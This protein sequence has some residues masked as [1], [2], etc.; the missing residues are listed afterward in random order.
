VAPVY[1]WRWHVQRSPETAA[2]LDNQWYQE[3]ARH[4]HQ[5]YPSPWAKSRDGALTVTLHSDGFAHAPP[6]EKERLK[7]L[8]SF[9]PGRI[10]AVCTPA[11]GRGASL[12]MLSAL[13]S[14]RYGDAFDS[15]VAGRR[16][17]VRLRGTY[18][19]MPER[20]PG[21][22][23]VRR[24]LPASATDEDVETLRAAWND[25]QAHTAL[26]RAAF[27]TAQPSLLRYRE[28]L[29]AQLRIWILSIDEALDYFETIAKGE[30]E[31]FLNSVV[32]TDR[33]TY[34]HERTKQVVRTR[35][36]VW[37]AVGRWDDPAR[38]DVRDYLLS[39]DTR[40]H[41]LL[42]ARDRIG[43][44]YYTSAGL[45]ANDAVL[46]HLNYFFLLVTAVFDNLAWILR[47]VYKLDL[48]KPQQVGVRRSE[49]KERINTKFD[50]LFAS[51]ES[52]LKVF[53]GTRHS[54]AHRL[55]MWGIGFRDDET[56]GGANLVETSDDLAAAVEAI[57]P[58]PSKRPYS[59]WG[60]VRVGPA[61]LL[62]P[63]R[64]TTAA[65]AKLLRLVDDFF[66]LLLADETIGWEVP[67]ESEEAPDPVRKLT[68]P[69]FRSVV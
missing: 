21:D 2:A 6:K 44:L 54:V 26:E 61:A 4:R 24:A 53:Y 30:G 28:S 1:Y 39:L 22:L 31:Y 3:L 56:N 38:N 33:W 65:L 14:I 19:S 57:D 66:A 60:L 43:Y 8:L 17:Q 42:E 63:Y 49:F 20:E 27:L 37:Q 41:Y 9:V 48:D 59:Q 10:D 50:R 47:H 46:Y 15:A 29:G 11:T 16:V 35:D 5:P 34:Y 62:E 23:E 52:L 64:F 69:F 51:R 13:D 45:N 18:T 7:V 58:A 55:V 67:A 36:R 32:T 68:I 40:L 12:D 25:L